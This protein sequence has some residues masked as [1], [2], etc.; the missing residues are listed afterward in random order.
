MDSLSQTTG[1]SDTFSR[2]PDK[3]KAELQIFLRNESQKSTIQQC[4]SRLPAHLK[5]LIPFHP[6]TV[7]I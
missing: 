6:T 1:V 7:S 4:T 5:S 2:L 3:D